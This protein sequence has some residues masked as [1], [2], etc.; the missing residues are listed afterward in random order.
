MEREVAISRRISRDELARE[1]M[2]NRLDAQLSNEERLK[3]SDV[4][5][6]NNER[7]D[8]FLE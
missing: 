4:I 3:Y 8:L 2:I 7:A 5:L 1:A 6:S